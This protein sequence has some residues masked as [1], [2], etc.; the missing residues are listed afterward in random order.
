MVALSHLDRRPPF[1]PHQHTLVGKCT[2]VYGISFFFELCRLR[3]KT[4]ISGRGAKSPA[5]SCLHP[6]GPTVYNEITQF[7]WKGLNP[8]SATVWWPCKAR[9]PSS[10]SFFFSS[11]RSGFDNQHHQV[12]LKRNISP[13]LSSSCPPFFIFPP[14]PSSFVCF[15]TA[16]TLCLP[17]PPHYWICRRSGWS[18]GGRG[19]GG[20]LA[21]CTAGH[22]NSC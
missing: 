19:G 3:L 13:P 18:R 14:S 1:Q 17:L 20:G 21:G 10:S 11:L 15:S 6:C 12:Q 5:P 22:Q 7:G 9:P 16:C 4:E 2:R 8:K